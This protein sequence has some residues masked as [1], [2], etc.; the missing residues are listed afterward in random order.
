M[1]RDAIA[2][3]GGRK[4]DSNPY[5]S[6]NVNAFYEKSIIPLR[7]LLLKK[8]TFL[9]ECFPWI[10][11][12]RI[13]LERRQFRIAL[14][15]IP[16]DQL[17]ESLKRNNLLPVAELRAGLSIEAISQ[18]D[19][20]PWKKMRDPQGA[21][22]HAAPPHGV[23]PD[24]VAPPVVTDNINDE[25]NL[26]TPAPAVPET[27]DTEHE[28]LPPVLTPR[29]ILT[30]GA[31]GGHTTDEPKHPKNTRGRSRS[32]RRDKWGLEPPSPKRV[33]S[34]SSSKS[35]VSDTPNHPR[36]KPQTPLLKPTADSGMPPPP[37]PSAPTSA[38]GP[39]PQNPPTTTSSTRAKPKPTGPSIASTTTTQRSASLSSKLPL[40]GRI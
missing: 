23:T 4:A 9:K 35:N 32:I 2:S 40:G 17:K 13:Q 37:A 38:S 10:K 19:N 33:R 28:F 6:A 25:I 7:S 3:H 21:T 30:G 8:A 34:S 14:I 39:P 22:G 29:T 11:Y 18:V 24:L 1:L 12:T 36:K 31:A 27:M 20:L 15:V 16:N 5:K 26:T